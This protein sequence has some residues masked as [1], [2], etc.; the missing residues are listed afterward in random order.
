MRAT[1][2]GV[3][4]SLRELDR[5]QTVDEFAQRS[6]DMLWDLIP[7]QDLSFNELDEARRRVDFYRVRSVADLEDETEDE[8]WAYAD[9]LP[10]CL[11]IPPGT[12]GVVRTQDIVSRR[13]L[14]SS[15]IYSEVLHPNG[16][17]FEMK[18]AFESP[19]WISRAFL[20][21]TR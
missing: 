11:G 15:K 20:F 14:L 9:D 6:I 12:A 13:A 8:F 21:W 3:I 19:P 2:D 1:L 5:C 18:M 16:I 10:I 4:T 7:C 17:E